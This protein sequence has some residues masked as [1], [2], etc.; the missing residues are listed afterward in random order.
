[1]RLSLK[2]AVLIGLGAVLLVLVMSALSIQR[3]R[4][5]I[6]QDLQRDA[7]L[8][9]TSVAVAS[10]S[11][12]PADIEDLTARI[13]AESAGVTVRY[14]TEGSTPTDTGRSSARAVMPLQNGGSIEVTESLGGLDEMMQRS[15]RSLLTTAVFMLLLSLIA[16]LALGRAV[17]GARVDALVG[18]ARQ[19]AE[20]QFDTP[21]LLAG[22]DE[23]SL[24]ASELN[25]MALRLKQ[26]RERSEREA[27]ARI[28]AEIGLRHADRLQTVGQLSAGLAHELGTPL[29]VITGRASL[30]MRRMDVGSSE[31]A[32]VYTIHEQARR[33]TSIVR[34][35]MDFSRRSPAHKDTT[36]L[37][38]LVQE[39]L[40]LIQ[41]TLSRERIT[42]L[43]DDLAPCRIA[44]DPEQIRQV[45]TNLLLNAA[46]ATG[47]G[48]R[49]ASRSSKG[50][51][52]WN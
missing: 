20:G 39:T 26:A 10:V 43:S 18:K 8:I 35:L 45:I 46:Q 41:P 33:I 30:L 3:D 2:I 15:V 23:L 11:L 40:P 44:G 22:S 37:S 31:H 21:V 38:D 36:E 28:Q 32:D 25:A 9:A 49:F 17:V 51:A 27:S 1:M 13:S 5:I 12:S 24:L 42:L 29:N 50:L 7:Q 6:L 47:E 14:L 34:Q 16:G 48:G 4:Q 52:P 19:V